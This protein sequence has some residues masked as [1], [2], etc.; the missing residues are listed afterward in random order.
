M[1]D[2]SDEFTRRILGVFGAA[3]QAWLEQ[4]PHLLLDFSRRWKLR[5]G[6][7]FDL[8]YNYVVAAWREDCS[9]VV[10]KMGVPHRELTS[11]IEATRLFAG[12]GCARLLEAEPERGALLLERLQPGKMLLEVK[13]D[14]QATRIAAGVMRQL[15]RPVEAIPALIT[16]EAWAAGLARL[17][18]RFGGATGP[19]P[20]A[21]VSRAEGLFAELLPSAPERLLL[22]GDLHHANILSAARQPWLAIDPK[23]V[24]GEPAFEPYALL[25]N[26]FPDAASWPDLRRVQA[27]R[28]DILRDELGLDRQRM[29]GYA[30]A[31]TVLS[32]WWDYEDH[33]AGWRQDLIFAEALV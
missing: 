9:P 10:L 1:P 5:L 14:D 25:H 27:R 33:S 21:L 17:R 18:P 13:D 32:A 20:P 26:P 11:E 28:L 19:F 22:H 7:P 2:L 15:W 30:I 23:G 24:L 8:S 6:D 4:L 29:H 31:M 16:A 12:Q 3:G